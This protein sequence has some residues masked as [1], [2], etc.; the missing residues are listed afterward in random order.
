MN[1]E[2]Y[3]SAI[4]HKLAVLD[5]EVKISGHLNLLNIHNHAE[6]FYSV[7][8]NKVFAL[9]LS[10]ANIKQSNVTAI[11]L[12]DNANKVIFQVSSRND[13]S[14]IRSSLG[15]INTSIYNGFNFKY[16]AISNSAA[17]LRNGNYNIPQGMTFNPQNDIYDINSLTATIKNIPDIDKIEDISKFLQKELIEKYFIRPN[18]ITEIINRLAKQ[19]SNNDLPQTPLPFGI[20]E[21]I[22]YNGLK[23]WGLDIAELA[24]YTSKVNDIYATFVTEGNN[25]S[26]AVLFSLRRNYL[27]LKDS[28]TGDDLFD[29]LLE[30]VYAD[31]DGDS[32]C[33][34]SITTEE[35][36]FNISIILVDAFM[37]C[38]IFE[39]PN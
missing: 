34:N 22:I 30:K 19:P 32:C 16:L 11:D 3:I 10:N 33:S 28:F 25:K 39:R 15:K 17:N 20:P 12:V 13:L 4:V 9:S 24:I 31:V 23:N 8:L 18:V 36:K 21:K 35:L 1:R 26:N 14:K 38:K 27:S 5:S 37:R 29:K 2:R 7:L 6:N